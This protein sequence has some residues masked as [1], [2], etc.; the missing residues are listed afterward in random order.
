MSDIKAGHYYKR[1]NGPHDKCARILA[2]AEK[3][4]MFRYKGCA[5]AL[6]DEKSFLEK[7]IRVFTAR[8]SD[9][10]KGGAV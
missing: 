1:I 8:K 5:V 10:S 3:H 7:H 2:V 6:S 9:A 4:V